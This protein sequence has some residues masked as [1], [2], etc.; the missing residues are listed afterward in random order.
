MTNFL[1]TK[2][3]LSVYFWCFFVVFLVA[4]I[5]IHGTN[6]AA[7][8]LTLFS[9]NSFLYG[10]YISPILSAQKSRIDSLHQI[11]RAE[12]NA[13]FDMVLSFKKLPKE[14]YDQLK[15]LVSDY[16][17]AKLAQRKM[18]AGEIEYE[19]IITY[20]VEYKGEAQDKIDG[21]LQDLV[22]N[23]L[24]RTNFNMQRGNKV[25]TNEWYIMAILF[26]ITLGLYF[27]HPDSGLV[28]ISR[29]ASAALHGLN[30]ADPEPY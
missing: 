13:L 20:C 24:N 29:G 30:N 14:P 4:S 8:P 22:S 15:Q 3:R 25:F 5:F 26:S 16:V 2:V 6:F 18:D 7:G 12:A 23:Q 1:L 27:V 10:F 17:H 9:V 28:D 11:I 21:V 19:K